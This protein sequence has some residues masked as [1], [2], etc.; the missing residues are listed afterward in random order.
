[1][2]NESEDTIIV[3]VAFV[4]LILAVVFG[5][6]LYVAYQKGIEIKQPIEE[7]QPIEMPLYEFTKESE[8]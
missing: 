2:N 6:L 7:I 4:G 1:M 3:G 8:L 5:T